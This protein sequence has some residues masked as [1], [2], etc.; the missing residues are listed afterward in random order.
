M[1]HAVEFVIVCQYLLFHMH[2]SI[3]TINDIIKMNQELSIK[4][5]RHDPIL[6]KASDINKQQ[7]NK[8]K[9]SIHQINKYSIV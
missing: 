9:R 3:V 5:K 7:K 1:S 8:T 4:Q 6:H 2:T